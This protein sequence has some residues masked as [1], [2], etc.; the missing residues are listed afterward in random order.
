LR[1]AL[2]ANACLGS[3]IPY[4]RP[5]ACGLVAFP[6]HNH[7]LVQVNGRFLFNN[8]GFLLLGRLPLVAFDKIHIFHDCLACGWNHGKDFARDAFVFSAH[9]EDG[10][11]FFYSK[12]HGFETPPSL[13]Y[14]RSQRNNF[15]EFFS[16]QFPADGSENSCTQGFILFIYQHRGIIIEPDVRPIFPAQFFLGS[17]DYSADDSSFFYLCFRG[18]FPDR[19]YD[20]IA[21]AGIPTSSSTQDFET[22]YAF[23]AGVIRYS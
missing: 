4:T 5:Y 15:H 9:H 18:R 3:I 16:P 2:P 20:N 6:A 12:G 23:R 1:A 7:E 14:L 11:A 22:A 8:P 13:H 19:S 17:N 21:D 10:I